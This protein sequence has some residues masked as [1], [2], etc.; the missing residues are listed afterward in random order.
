MP[1]DL[2]LSST[3]I[4]SNYPCLELIFMVPKVFEPLKFDCIKFFP[5]PLQLRGNKFC[6][7]LVASLDNVALPKESPL[8]SPL[9]T[10]K[11]TT[12]FTSSKFQN[13]SHPSYI[14]LRMQRLKHTVLVCMRWPIL[15][16]LIKICN[17]CKF[18][19]F[20]LW[21]RQMLLESKFFPLGR[22]RKEV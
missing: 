12:E 7:S 18:K 2:A 20:R 13:M 11:Q 9:S 3:L 22:F 21:R 1:S 6:D 15:S 16:H 10:K 5:P 14:I 8:F 19:Y 4:G 17:A